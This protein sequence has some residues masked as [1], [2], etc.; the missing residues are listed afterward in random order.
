MLFLSPLI[1]GILRKFKALVHSRIGPPLLQPYWDILKL[2]GKDDVRSPHALLGPLPSW[3]ALA[4]L[5]AAGLLVPLGTASA[6]AGGDL[7]LFLYLVGFASVCTMLAGMDSGSPYAFLG[8][9]REMMTSFVVEP[10]LFVALITAALK[11]HSFRFADMA[12]FQQVSGTS[13]SMVIS[14]AALLLAIQAQ[15]SKLPFDIPE[16]E[17]ELMGGVFAEMSGPT[18]AM[19]R[20]GFIVKQVVFALVLT[21]I[22]FP[23]PLGLT[24]LWAV[25]AQIVKVLLVAVAVGLV[26]AVNPRLRIDQAVVYYFGV[27]LMALVGLVFALVGA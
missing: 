24:G 7:F 10:V 15:L 2:L 8:A 1:E 9:G 6:F 17:G 26:D 27:V 12:F 23:W 22:F 11:S 16:A 19:Y 3:L 18:F 14:G 13:V 4:A 20:W 21:Q 5:L 25:I